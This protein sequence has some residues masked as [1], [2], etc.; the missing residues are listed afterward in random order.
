M[1]QKF[2]QTFIVTAILANI[3][4]GSVA[5]AKKADKL[6]EPAR[7]ADPSSPAALHKQLLAVKR[8][9]RTGDASRAATWVRLTDLHDYSAKMTMND[10]VS[11][12]SSQASL[13]TEAG[14][15][16]LASIYA[17]Q[18]VKLAPDPLASELGPAWI[19]LQRVSEKRPIQN[20]LEIVASST[21]LKGR[22][23]PVFGSD[24]NYFA[25]SAAAHAG[26]TDKALKFYGDLKVGDRY[27]FPAKYQQAMLLIELEKPAAAEDALKAILFSTAQKLSALT[28]KQRGDMAD[29]AHL[30]LGRLY[31]ERQRFGE[32]SKMY[33]LVS[34][35]GPNFY[36]ALFEQSWSLFMAGYPMHAL[37]GLYAVESPFYKETFNPEA[38]LL[39]AMIHYW[40]CRYDSSRNALADFMERYQPDVEKLTDFLARKHL[41]AETAYALFE[42]LVAGVSEESL[43]L[44]RSILQTAAQKDSMLLVRDQYATIIEERSR[45]EAKGIFGNKTRSNQSLGYM[46]R[47]AQALRKEVG[48]RFLAELQDMKKDYDRLFAQAE[49]LYVELLMSEKD[50][51]LGKEL[52]ASSKITNVSKR[53]QVNSWSKQ[54]QSWKDARNGEYWWDELGYYIEPVESMCTVQG[55]NGK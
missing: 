3:A 2:S 22:K 48:K 6:K 8:A 40:L 39:R 32:S 23:A 29:Y 24:W 51:L 49:F 44:S 19:I 47:W 20:V 13:L 35:D 18:A 36:D 26:Q 28:E 42:N 31:Y 50:Q 5:F 34:R 21:D 17:S 54:S 33:R 45:L 14:Y 53:M 1:R 11:L 27:F 16:V 25:G 38:P 41:D 9:Y 52:H 15:P 7:V 10:R 4:G 12:L 37:G 46:D 43:G 30:A 55:K